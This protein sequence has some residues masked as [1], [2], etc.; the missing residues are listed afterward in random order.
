[1]IDLQYVAVVSFGTSFLMCLFQSG[2]MWGLSLC[3]AAFT[4]M[5]C[6]GLASVV[7]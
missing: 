5:V 4:C 3:F 7:M 2:G 1:M 6:T